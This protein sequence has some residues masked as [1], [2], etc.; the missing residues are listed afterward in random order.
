VQIVQLTMLACFYLKHY[1]KEHNTLMPV[2]AIGPINTAKE[3]N[4]TYNKKT[5]ITVTLLKLQVC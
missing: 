5:K 4:E 1:R 3:Y 2:K